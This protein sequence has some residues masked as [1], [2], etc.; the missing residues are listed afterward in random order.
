MAVLIVEKE[1]S[2]AAAKHTLSVGS[3]RSARLRLIHGVGDN[4]R[5]G[6][7][8][9]RRRARLLA[10][11]I[12]VIVSLLVSISASIH[13]FDS[14]E[15]TRINSQVDDRRSLALNRNEL[16]N[17]LAYDL[18]SGNSRLAARQTR[19]S[20][21]A[22]DAIRRQAAQSSGLLSAAPGDLLGYAIEMDCRNYLFGK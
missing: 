17:E 8:R 19:N 16:G 5:V 4:I 12:V 14:C 9:Q 21:S 10:T 18:V 22:D 3:D 15:A 1:T 13:R 6:R 11:M 7:Q 20:L 2:H